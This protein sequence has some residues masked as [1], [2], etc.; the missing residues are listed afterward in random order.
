MSG[1]CL[2]HKSNNMNHKTPSG[3]LMVILVCMTSFMNAQTKNTMEKAQLSEDQT[4]VMEVIEKMTSSFHNKDIE[5][6]MRSYE[7]EAVIV[8]EPG[9]PVS[10]HSLLREMFQGAFTISPK[11]VY[12]GH[13]VF[14]SGDIATHFAPW[15][16]T[17]KAPD[18]TEIKQSGLSVAVLRKQADGKWLMIF[19]NPHGQ[20]L[21]DKK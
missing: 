10:G 20:T 5:G 17:G 16:M 9:S 3:F 13:E 12:S 1:L 8:F 21:M 14:V 15:T 6:V 19:D 2:S 11:F 7:P 18:G 4:Q